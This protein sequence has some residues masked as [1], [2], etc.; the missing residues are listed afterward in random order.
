M[1]KLAKSPIAKMKA[2]KNKT[3]LAYIKECYRKSDIGIL[4]AIK[5][6]NKKIEN[7]EKITAGD[8][9]KK[10]IAFEKEQGVIDLSFNTILIRSRRVSPGMT[11]LK[12]LSL[13]VFTVSFLIE[14][15][16]PSTAHIVSTPFSTS[17]SEPV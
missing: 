5:F 16:Y 3:E 15:R 17:K 12:L 2:T 6:L 8:F 11:K 10:L 7:K 14:R 9:L 1:K 13:I 4:K